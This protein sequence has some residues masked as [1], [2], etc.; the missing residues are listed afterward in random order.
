MEINDIEIIEYITQLNISK[1]IKESRKRNAKEIVAQI[2]EIIKRK[3]KMYNCDR[4][5][6]NELLK[7]K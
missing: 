5:Q 7:I 3:E 1:F 6:L 2:Q 4:E